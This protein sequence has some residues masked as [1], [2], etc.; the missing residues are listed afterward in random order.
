MSFLQRVRY[1]IVVSDDAEPEA[2]PLQS[3]EEIRADNDSINEKERLIGLLIAPVAAVIG[4][5]V[6]GSSISNA[7]LHHQSYSIY[8]EL[9]YMLLAMSVLILVTAL[10]R[11]RLYLGIATTLFGL[12]IFN[13]RYP[14]FGAPFVLIGAWYLVRAYRMQQNLRRAGGGR[15]VPARGGTLAKG[16][17]PRPNKRYTPPV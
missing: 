11:K 12:G 2:E 8:S 9:T 4:L 13:L 3:V 15:S 7:K 1:S 10:L 17:R 6:G 14:G 5:I 16:A